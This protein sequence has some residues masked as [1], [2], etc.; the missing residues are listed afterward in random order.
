MKLLKLFIPLYFFALAGYSQ[1]I[2]GQNRSKTDNNLELNYSSPRILEIANID[3]RGLQFLDNNALISLSGLKVGDKIKIPGDEISLA[4]K[5]LWK[6]G[7]IGNIAIFATKI[8]GNQIWLVIELTERPRLLRYEFEGISKSHRTELEDDIELTKGK[9]I[10][11]V[12]IKNTQL[13]VKK[14]YE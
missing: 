6:Q 2:F 11:D 7:I 12:V 3:I 14:F 8:E 4:I 10:T 1:L 9:I 13:T 5:K